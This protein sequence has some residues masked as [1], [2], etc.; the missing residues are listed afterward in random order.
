MNPTPNI[1]ISPTF[2]ND[3]YQFTE[4]WR[5]PYASENRGHAG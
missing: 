4:K 1:N 5:R 3:I 2:Y